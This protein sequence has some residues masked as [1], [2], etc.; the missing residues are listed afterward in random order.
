M[1]LS[2]RHKNRDIAELNLP[3]MVD[4]ILLLLIFFMCTRSFNDP[5][6][7]I[8][9]QLLQKGMSSSNEIADI[10]PISI[11]LRKTDSGIMLDCDGKKYSSFQSLSKTLEMLR[12]IVDAKVI[13]KSEA[14]VPFRYVVETLDRCKSAGFSNVGLSTV[15][16]G[17]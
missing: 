11:T 3:A 9:S 7:N 2:N 10:E 14:Q 1:K 17:E 12:N 5:E 13:I 6:K 4:V 15:E 16:I 8:K